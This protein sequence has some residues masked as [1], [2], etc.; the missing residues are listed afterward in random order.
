VNQ[1]KQKAPNYLTFLLILVGL[2]AGF[3][4]TYLILSGQD[5]D[6]GIEAPSIAPLVSL[7]LIVLLIAFEKYFYSNY[8]I[9]L[10]T[11]RIVAVTLVILLLIALNIA[12]SQ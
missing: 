11:S 12:I 7:P 3:G 9:N 2:A 6:A 5:G 4:L 10:R 1:N 8:R